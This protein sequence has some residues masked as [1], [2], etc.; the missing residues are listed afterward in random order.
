MRH[1]IA[2]VKELVAFQRKLAFNDGY[3]AGKKAAED[4]LITQRAQLNLETAKATTA[5]I[6]QAGKIMSKA[7]YMLGKLDPTNKGW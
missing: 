2:S 3:L 4:E 7:G 1:T 6:E 5:L